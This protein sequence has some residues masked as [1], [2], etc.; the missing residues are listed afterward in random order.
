MLCKISVFVVFI[1]AL[2]LTDSAK[3]LGYFL[4]PSYSHQIVYQKIWLELARRGHDVTV[5]TPNPTK[6]REFQNLKE[7]DLSDSYKVLEEHH[8]LISDYDDV[9][10]VEDTIRLTK[11]C[12]LVLEQQLTHPD[13]QNLIH[14]NT[15]QYDLLV[16][17]FV[18]PIIFGLKEVVKAPMVGILTFE[19]SLSWHD[20]MRSP[21]HP[22]ATPNSF[23]P[24]YKNLTFLERLYSV[25]HSVHYRV[26]LVF[27]VGFPMRGLL[28]QIF[29]TTKNTFELAAETSIVFVNTPILGL[30]RPTV[31]QMITYSGL[32]LKGPNELSQL[33]KDLKNILDTAENG[34]IYFSLGSNIKSDKLSDD[35]KNELL[36]AFSQL[37]YT[38]LW[39]FENDS[40]ANKPGN[41]YISKWY[42]QQE[43]LA[44]PNV[45]LFIT[46][47]GLQS[48]EEAIHFGVPLIG[49]PFYADQHHNAR[50]IVYHKIGVEVD[51]KTFTA[52][53]LKSSI[54]EVI[55]NP[56]YK[57]KISK[58]SELSREKPMDDLE[59]IVWYMEY[60][61][62]HQGAPYLKNSALDLPLYQY[63]M[64][65][66]YA[67]L[68]I[69]AI[70][71]WRI[72]RKLLRVLS[73]VFKSSP[74]KDKRD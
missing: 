26:S 61:I 72:M 57:E 33:P 51:Y 39:K 56:S 17:E 37:P 36:T 65:D 41:V 24:M 71:I 43:V 22:I 73:N 66:V 49:M 60:V 6:S 27:R 38:V 64:L 69:S 25:Y 10:Y 54:E 31:P 7:V 46:Q 68:I 35:K 15:E 70:L 9:D 44:H 34:V 21:T 12:K 13:V 5:F 59:K 11:L 1:A 18:Y 48:L 32:H 30:P 29:N 3:I 50:K 2:S 19:P 53:S 14:N 74:N 67:F 42:P 28:Y 45:K 16:V 20:Y 62:R 47:V 23:L 52:E 8:E 40:I 63:L 55:R 4:Y 58:I